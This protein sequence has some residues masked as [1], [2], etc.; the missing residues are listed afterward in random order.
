MEGEQRTIGF[1]DLA[2]FTALTDRHGDQEAIEVAMIF[3]SHAREAV[4]NRGEV[5]KTIG[6]AVMLAFPTPAP[7][8]A[9]LRDLLVHCQGTINQPALRSGL[10]HGPV[11]ARDDDWFGATVN[12]AARVTATAPSGE[13]HV[14]TIVADVARDQGEVVVDLGAHRLRH[15]AEPV[16]LWAV[17][18]VEPPEATSIDPVCHMRVDHTAAAAHVRDRGA[19]LWFCS[20]S[21]LRAYLDHPA[22]FDPSPRGR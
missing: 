10:H 6:D 1:V 16:A 21:C 20:T 8:L 9:A 14:T 17:R 4:T 22:M 3:F 19:D 7:A 11:L 15:L 18:L 13:T 12:I 5:V 2:G